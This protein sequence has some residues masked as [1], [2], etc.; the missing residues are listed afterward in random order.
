MPE[1]AAPSLDVIR[2]CNVHGGQKVVMDP[3]VAGH[4]PGIIEAER[5]TP[6][7]GDPPT[8]FG[9]QQDPRR[10]VPR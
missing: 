2:R 10:G 3:P 6:M 9:H 8:G 5:V 7:V 4:Y 1:R